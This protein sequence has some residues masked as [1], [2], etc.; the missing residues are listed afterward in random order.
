MTAKFLAIVIAVVI[1]I[2]GAAPAPVAQPDSAGPGTPLPALATPKALQAGTPTPATNPQPAT[3]DWGY[4]NSTQLAT[5]KWQSSDSPQTIT[6]WYKSKIEALGMPAKSFVQT[7]TNGNFLNKLVA[8]N[9]SSKVTVEISKGSG[10]SQT[11]IL[12][13]LDN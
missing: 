2:A 11:S 9:G 1:W 10:N 3:G 5:G 7:N 13:V 12:V 6:N 8:A 4:P